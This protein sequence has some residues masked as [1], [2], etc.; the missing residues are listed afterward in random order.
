HQR[1]ENGGKPVTSLEK[2]GKSKKT[3]TLIHFKPDPTMFSVTT[4]N[5]DTLSE[6]LRESAF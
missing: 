2:V 1:F 3:G 4:Y 6:R 5:F